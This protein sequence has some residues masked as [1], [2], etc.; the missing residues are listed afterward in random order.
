M[1]IQQR[2]AHENAENEQRAEMER[3]LKMF[4]AKFGL[5]TEER[6]ESLRYISKMLD[7]QE[8]F[9][10]AIAYESHLDINIR[11]AVL[12]YLE[13]FDDDFQE[14]AS[15]L[16]RLAGQAREERARILATH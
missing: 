9:V 11:S 1:N 3:E 5:E 12:A 6:E 8:N 15:E 14:M 10:N 13:M 4:C 2:I 7:E 16:N